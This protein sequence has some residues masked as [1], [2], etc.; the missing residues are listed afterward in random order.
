MFQTLNILFSVVETSF[1]T[2]SNGT[3]LSIATYPLATQIHIVT[4]FSILSNSTSK[5]VGHNGMVLVENL[6]YATT[7]A[8]S[9]GVALDETNR[10]ATR[11]VCVASGHFAMDN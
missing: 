1:A 9:F 11:N 5:L 7:H 8:T 3:Q 10:I 2:R 6:S 4:I